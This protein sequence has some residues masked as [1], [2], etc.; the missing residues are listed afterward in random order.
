MEGGGSII[1]PFTSTNF[2]IMAFSKRTSDCAGLVCIPKLTF[3]SSKN[4]IYKNSLN[5]ESYKRM[6]CENNKDQ[7]FSL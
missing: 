4:S 6:T 7:F 5:L 1:S 2:Q 3:F